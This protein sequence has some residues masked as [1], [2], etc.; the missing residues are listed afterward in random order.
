M[1][2]DRLV[3]DLLALRRVMR[4]HTHPI[5]PGDITPQQ[6]W[7]LRL[8]YTQGRMNISALAAELDVSASATTT[9]C[10]RLEAKGLV[11][12]HRSPVDVRIVEIELTDLGRQTVEDWQLRRREA[13][14]E[15][16]V[17]L[18]SEER[19]SLRELI[20]QILNPIEPTETQG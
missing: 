2:S 16:L 15:L 1:S 5:Q 19:Q 20:E 4:L 10:R 3:E 18:D 7:L 11:V 12:R 13:M 14:S 8:L 9:T 6:F 17:P